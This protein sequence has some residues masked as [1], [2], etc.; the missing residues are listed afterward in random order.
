[1]ESSNNLEI[2]LHSAKNLFDVK[3]FGTMDPYAMIWITG[4]GVMSEIYK[5]NVAKNA[6]SCPVWDYPILLKV[7]PMIKN[8]TLFCE[9]Q[10]HGK[11]I[12]R[13]IGEVQ[14]PFTELLAGDGS[15]TR[16][17]YPVKTCSGE[18]KGEIII[19]CKFSEP[20]V[21]S[22]ANTSN[23]APGISGRKKNEATGTGSGKGGGPAK[24]KV[25]RKK[26]DGLTK[27]IAK[28]VVT[29]VATKAILLAGVAGI[30]VGTEYFDNKTEGEDGDG[31]ADDDVDKD[32]LEDD[33][34][35]GVEDEDGVVDD[36]DVEDDEDV[37]EDEDDDDDY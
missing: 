18:V 27:R 8:Y 5:T 23:G 33:A 21:K 1:M 2:V 35:A 32:G 4:G 6:G 11:L 20:V 34:D 30:V 13:K 12:D 9:I 25:Q 28:N 7:D 24:K 31:L 16:V 37:V 36:Q 19:S 22:G 15:R 3:N 14:V 17:S 29:Q 26:K 10:H